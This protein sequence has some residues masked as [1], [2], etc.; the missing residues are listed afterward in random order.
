MFSR[1]QMVRINIEDQLIRKYFPGFTLRFTDD[2]CCWEGKMQTNSDKTYEI[3]AEIPKD[4]PDVRPH[5]YITCPCPVYDYFG[6]N[7]ATLGVS[8]KMH[9]YSPKGNWVQLCVY[10]DEWWSAEYTVYKC[11]KKARLWIEAFDVH[12]RTGKMMCDLLG[13][14]K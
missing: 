10:R 14:Q 4:Y 12:K 8:H 1:E 11:L 7:L 9:T 2:I 3:Q 6:N 5:I 13:T